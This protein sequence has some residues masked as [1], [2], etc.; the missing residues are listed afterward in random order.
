M[1]KKLKILVSII[2]IAPLVFNSC[3]DDD[4]N[5]DFNLENKNLRQYEACVPLAR[6]HIEMG[7]WL[8]D[9]ISDEDAIISADGDS[10]LSIEFLHSEFLNW[11]ALK[12][13]GVDAEEYVFTITEDG[14]IPPPNFPFTEEF[15]HR[16]NIAKQ[17]DALFT[18]I[19]YSSGNLEI[20]L[21]VPDGIFGHINF[22][23]P[24]IKS[25]GSVL[26]F[27][28]FNF[29]PNQRT[30]ESK[31]ALKN[32]EII[33]VDNHISLTSIFTLND[34]V[35][36]SLPS[37]FKITFTLKDMEVDVAEG[38][39]GK[40]RVNEPDCDFKFSIFDDLQI[41][42]AFE[43]D[44][45]ILSA[46]VENG[47][48]VPFRATL[49]DVIIF[50]DDIELGTL[51]KLSGD[52]FSLDVTTATNNPFTVGK[53]SDYIEG[54]NSP[55]IDKRST[56]TDFGNNYTHG[57]NRMFFNLVGIANYN[58]NSGN[59]FV[60]EEDDVEVKLSLR[61]PFNFWANPYQ[62]RDTV[63]FDVNELFDENKH[64]VESF[65]VVKL[66]LDIEN[67]LPFDAEVSVYVLDDNDNHILNKNNQPYYLDLD[68]KP[69]LVSGIPNDKGVIEKAEAAEEFEI[70]IKGEEM[71][72]FMDKNVKKI[73]FHTKSK[74]YN[75]E[76]KNMVKVFTYSTMDI[77]ISMEA[78][79]KVPD[80]L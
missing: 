54:R 26:Q 12:D 68:D 64:L 1:N 4:I 23:I 24:E 72:Y 42:D 32:G 78:I 40:V 16:V 35:S 3:K 57:P 2:L 44:N 18:R 9:L 71:S 31:K 49:E 10:V 63:D 6:V 27:E 15:V 58:Q 66:Y 19:K 65:E 59:N 73:V 43:F 8:R 39:F 60:E 75:N 5:V 79:A 30:Y 29:A 14:V 77:H 74:T 45:I 76:K 56:I 28:Q 13:V 61:F 7:K 67:K 11:N 20:K 37:T 17:E 21:E 46:T 34:V 38:F 51:K 50:S 62:R 22:S 80:K 48:G 52:D 41:V 70:P 25:E 69:F 33:F 47:I 53:G 55:D 36:G